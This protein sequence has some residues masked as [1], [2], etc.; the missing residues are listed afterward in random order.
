M[1]TTFFDDDLAVFFDVVD[2]TNT[3]LSSSSF[4]SSSKPEETGF[5]DA[6]LEGFFGAVDFLGTG[7][8]FLGGGGMPSSSE[9]DGSPSGAVA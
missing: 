4:S 7:A 2:F 3:I 9:P 1:C 8:T 6:A 5:F